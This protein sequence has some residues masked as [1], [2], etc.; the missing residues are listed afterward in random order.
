MHVVSAHLWLEFSLKCTGSRPGVF[1]PVA[2]EAQISSGLLVAKYTPVY[3]FLIPHSS[4]C[5]EE[6]FPPH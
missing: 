2:W 1:L 6:L 3:S 5:S 4:A